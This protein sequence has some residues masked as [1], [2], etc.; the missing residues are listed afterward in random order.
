MGITRVR[1][2]RVG[3]ATGFNVQTLM[4]AH[5]AS[6]TVEQTQPVPTRLA[7]LPVRAA[8]D[9]LLRVAPR[10]STLMNVLLG[11]ISV[12]PAQTAPT[13]QEAMRVRAAKGGRATERRAPTSMS[14]PP[15][16]PPHAVPM[17]SAAI[18]TGR[19]RVHA[20]LAG[21]E[22]VFHASTLP[23]AAACVMFMPRA[24]KSQDHLPV[25]AP[26]VTLGMAQ[27]VAISTNASL[28]RRV[29]YMHRAATLTG[30]LHARAI[31]AMSM[32]LPEVVTTLTNVW[33]ES[34]HAP[35]WARCVQTQMDRF[36]ARAPAGIPEMV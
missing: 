18:L 32:V 28:L 31:L 34:I 11:W 22:T 17:P 29:T 24:T 8:S 25:L 14:A 36:S 6:T 4:N 13:A 20:I 33:T 1:V 27:H 16:A 21:R 15:L 10:V 7:R 3:R 26:W 9:T 35:R 23:N 5:L 2:I 12:R 30:H 19:L